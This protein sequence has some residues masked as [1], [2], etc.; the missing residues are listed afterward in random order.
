[1][2]A[3]CASPEAPFASQQLML[4][5]AVQHWVAGF[6]LDLSVVGEVLA[7]HHAAPSKHRWHYG[8]L[9]Y[10]KTSY[11]PKQLCHEEVEVQL[12]SS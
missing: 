11:T 4:S 2:M 3:G 8:C 10:Q 12:A 9:G 6:C 1:M 7:E 5:A